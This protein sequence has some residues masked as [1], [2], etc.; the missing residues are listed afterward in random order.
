MLRSF[1]NRPI[2]EY[3]LVLPR[4]KSRVLLGYKKRGFGEND[5]SFLNIELPLGAHKWNGFGGKIESGETILDGAK[6]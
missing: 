3:T 4:D 2:K 6:R 1:A 5:A